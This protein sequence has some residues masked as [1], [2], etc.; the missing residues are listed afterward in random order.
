[1]AESL[2]VHIYKCNVS[3]YDYIQ[4][5]LVALNIGYTSDF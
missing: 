1:M 3:A 4:K 5:L 2:D